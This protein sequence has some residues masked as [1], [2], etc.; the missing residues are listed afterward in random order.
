MIRKTSLMFAAAAIATV[1]SLPLHA[2][3]RLTYTIGGSSVQVSWPASA[4]PIRYA[5]DRRV[6]SSLPN[7]ATVV[8]QAFSTWASAPDTNI[9]FQDAGVRDGLTAGKDGV[10]SITLA[11]DLFKGQYAIAM[12]TNWYDNSGRLSEADIMIDASLVNG[13]YNMPYAVTH[14]VGH[15]L[16]LDH[17]PVLSA[18]MFPYVPRGTD[19]TVLDSDDRIAIANIYPKAD[20]TLVGGILRGRVTGDSGAV[21]AAQVV[22]MN[23][24][25]A[26]VATALSD[27]RG[28][29]TLQALPAGTYR[30]YAEPLDGPVDR[31]NFAGIWRSAIQTSFPTRFCDSGTLH[32]ENGQVY[33]NLV[34]NTAGTP[35]QLNPRWVGVAPPFSDSFNLSS[36]ALTVRPGQSINVALAGD[37]IVSGMTTFDV[38]N[39]GFHRT[40]GFH[41]AGNYLYA[42]FDVAA[43][44]PPGSV[45]IL[46]S[47]GS[48]QEATLTGALRLQTPP[49][50]MRAA[51][52]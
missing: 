33:G 30:I 47:N 16:G 36:I 24:K 9:S 28:N 31:R 41:Y 50:R 19:P 12:T 46:A 51:H 34:V 44:A 40:S 20:P 27:Q 26:P 5:I 10:N 43:D 3:A 42:T 23:D 45:V 49:S 14:E 39:P 21:F 15:L 25:G 18:V 48:D 38:L 7:A 6:M 17:S 52:R 37:G 2:S 32:V 11:D 29:F 13:D 35:P 22:A 4:F 8:D 1:V